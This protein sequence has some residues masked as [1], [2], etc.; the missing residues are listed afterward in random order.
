MNF[1]KRQMDHNKIFV[2]VL[3]SNQGIWALEWLFFFF[4]FQITYFS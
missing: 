1:E 2:G 4:L 3:N